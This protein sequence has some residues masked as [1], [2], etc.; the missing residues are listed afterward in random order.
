MIS[1]DRLNELAPIFINA[2]SMSLR[3]CEGEA[4]A[5]MGCVNVGLTYRFTQAG[6]QPPT[7]EEWLE[8]VNYLLRA[9]LD[10]LLFDLVNITQVPENYSGFKKFLLWRDRA[11]TDSDR[12]MKLLYS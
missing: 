1:D 11:K 12:I 3:W 6:V 4:C 9:E 2:G 10:N 8:V 7:H 5:C